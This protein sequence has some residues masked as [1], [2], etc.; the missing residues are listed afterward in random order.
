M[1]I[2]N[3]TT[4]YILHYKQA[5][6]TEWLSVEL[7]PEQTSYT[8][9]MLKCGTTYNAKIQAQ[10]KISLGPPSE[11]LTATTRGGRK[12]IITSPKINTIIIIKD[13]LFSCNRISRV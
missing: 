3:I 1:Y 11:V 13:C 10:N 7:S 2:T 8:M 5:S 6:E 4:G 9:D 12:F